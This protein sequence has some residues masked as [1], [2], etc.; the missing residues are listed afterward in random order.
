MCGADHPSQVR[1]HPSI[2]TVVEGKPKLANDK[3]ALRNVM[4]PG[5]HESL[6]TRYPPYTT[7]T[8]PPAHVIQVTHLV[9]PLVSLTKVEIARP[10]IYASVLPDFKFLE[11]LIRL[12]DY[13]HR[14][15]TTIGQD[16]D[17]M[18]TVHPASVINSS[19][20]RL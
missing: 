20:R 9:Q 19:N 15:L 17:F 12:R 6:E 5:L 4:R 7:P 11:H 3:F 16:A 10:S 8:Q 2:G 18:W 13:E 1:R 14:S